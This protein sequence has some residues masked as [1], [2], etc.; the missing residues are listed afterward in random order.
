MSKRIALCIAT[1]GNPRALFETLIANL[2]GCSLP[3]TK[4]VV[5]LDEDDPTL[6]DIKVL[7]DALGQERIVASIAPRADTIGAVYNRCASAIDADV[8]INGADDVRIATPGWDAILSQAAADFPDGFGVMG[9]GQMPVPSMLPVL[10]AVTRRLID[11]MGYFVQDYTPYW[12]MDTWLY[13]IAVMIGRIRYLPIDVECLGPMRTRGLREVDYWARF[14]DETRVYRRA[15]A[16]A[17]L[18]SS[19]FLASVQGRQELRN[20]VEQACAQFARS[21]SI[22]RDPAYARQIEGGGYD[23]P[24]D[25]RYRRAKDRSLR[26]LEDLEQ[27]RTRVA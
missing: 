3:D 22:L 13:E 7:L 19:E 16:E 4:V 27:S 9:F 12:W 24:E 1:R 15:I 18:S 5:G 26:V 23:A 17:I 21:N 10:E 25:E 11:H 2:R 6:E 20:G 8:Y 14:F